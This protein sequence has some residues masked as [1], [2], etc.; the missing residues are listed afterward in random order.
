MRAERARIFLLVGVMFLQAEVRAE[1][2]GNHGSGGG[3]NPLSTITLGGGKNTLPLPPFDSG[4]VLSITQ[5]LAQTIRE[6]HPKNWIEL[7]K[8]T[9][10][11]LVNAT[12]PKKLPK[13][14][15]A[16]VS[17]AVDQL[18]SSVA[19]RSPDSWEDFGQVLNGFTNVIPAAVM[20]NI[21]AFQVLQKE[22]SEKNLDQA[23][24]D[25]NP[26][27]DK[28]ERSDEGK[29]GGP[30]PDRLSPEA[31]AALDKQLDRNI[32]KFNGF[33]APAKPAF[34][35]FNLPA[36]ASAPTGAGKKDGGKPGTERNDL[37][38]S[39]VNVFSSNGGT[40]PATPPMVPV[41]SQ[42]SP[43][44]PNFPGGDGK[45]AAPS[46]GDTFSDRSRES[47]TST[48][49]VGPSLQTAS[50]ESIG[51]LISSLV[52][53]LTQNP[54]GASALPSN[55]TAGA[56][57]KTEPKTKT[58]LKLRENGTRVPGTGP[59]GGA[60]YG[61]AGV[62]NNEEPPAK[63]NESW[64][65]TA[66]QWLK[67]ALGLKD[68][69]GSDEADGEKALGL[70][71][72]GSALTLSSLTDGHLGTKTRARVIASLAEA[73]VSESTAH[74]LYEGALYSAWGST[75]GF[76]AYALRRIRRKRS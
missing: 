33:E 40:S 47:S 56:V 16:R 50:N 25:A 19:Q 75:F 64:G 51:Q 68:P 66:E 4:Q 37:P 27:G 26:A 73:G 76:L 29:S 46:A 43:S 52:D 61:V 28:G 63:A 39:G 32:G 21:I 3:Q 72:D 34:S 20:E 6:S 62:G 5:N 55:G 30:I 9:G 44:F 65:G 41:L 38:S 59:G 22:A 12:N 31:R 49:T 15:Q 18:A 1:R 13:Y 36:P 45:P 17:R 71:D 54:Q 8:I 74:R 24:K 67:A 53:K 57:T 11:I 60:D 2:N 69:E 14:D 35:A 10:S 48:S 23:D 58:D 7:Q 42:N 70:T